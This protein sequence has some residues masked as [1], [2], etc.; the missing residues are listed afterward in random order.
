M[1]NTIFIFSLLFCL[2]S[3]G[4]KVPFTNELRDECSLDSDEKMRS[5][6]FSTSHTI[7]LD[8]ELESDSQNTTTN[9][10]LISSS[11]TK[12]ESIIIHFRTPL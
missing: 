6:Q 5:V 7:I 12:Q 3:C 1:K 2:I 4:V 10:T 9:G 8:Q 11:N